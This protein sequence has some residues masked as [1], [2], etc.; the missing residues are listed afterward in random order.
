MATATLA[1]VRPARPAAP[2]RL[3]VFPDYA[4]EDWPSM[5]LCAEMLL[6]ALPAAA[7]AGLLAT[8]LCPPLRRRAG[9]LPLLGRRRAFNADRLLNRL[10]DYPRF[11]RRRAAEFDLFHVCDHSYAQL[12][13]ALP[14]GRVGVYCHDLDTF[15]CLL[16]PARDPR[17]RWFRWVA[18][19]VLRGLQRAAVVFHSTQEVRREILGHGLI[20]PDRLVQAPLGVPPEYTPQAEPDGTAARLLAPLGGAPYVLHVGSCI[21]RK[22]IDVLLRVFAAARAELPGLWLVKVGGPWAAEHRRLLEELKVGPAVLQVCGLAR[23]TIAD[24]YRRAALV[25][26]PSAAEGFGLPLIEALAC[27]AAVVATDLPVFRE[28]GGEAVVYCPLGDVAAWAG[29][30]SALLDDPSRAPALPLRLARARRYSWDSHARIIA[31]AYL[32]LADG[33]R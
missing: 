3:A 21:P 26:L 33:G 29:T 5:D 17:P 4:E 2:L 32:K 18:R 23:R 20:D 12:V 22:R 7:G 27:G 15:R 1:D 13:H 31:G 10:W 11:A 25:L 19:R 14:A 6:N 16:E 28:V 24:L 9:R 8:R 30:V